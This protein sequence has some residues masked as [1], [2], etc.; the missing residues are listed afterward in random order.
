MPGDEFDL[1]LRDAGD[2]ARLAALSGGTRSGRHFT[3]AATGRSLRG[4]QVQLASGLR[5][6]RDAPGQVLAVERE[7][8]LRDNVD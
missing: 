3:A 6:V 1:A 4:A 8:W 7:Y 2:D 5:V